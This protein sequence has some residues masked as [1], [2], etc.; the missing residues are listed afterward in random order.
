MRTPLNE[1]T[2]A[3]QSHVI[4][5]HHYKAFREKTTKLNVLGLR[6]P[7]IQKLEH[8]GFS[9]YQEPSKS[10]L[11]TWTHI[12]N[13]T[14]I[15]EV[16]YLPLFYYRRNRNLLDP[17][18]WKT[19]KG[20]VNRIENWEHADALCQ[21]YSFFYEQHP[22]LVEPTLRAWN[23]SKNPW[24]KRASI[25][26]TIYY[27]SRNRNAPS[28]KTVF[29]LIEPLITHKN[30]YVQKAVGWQLREAYKLE[31]KRALTFIQRHL[32]ELAPISY[33]YATEHVPAQTR[34]SM[35]ERRRLFRALQK[36]GT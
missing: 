35:K 1:V 6:L 9:F 20:W 7:V 16:M 23:K 3:L 33:S 30:P 26:S 4:S 19:M 12:W 11:E 28:L 5:D 27:A 36:K 34:A 15:H 32:V 13:T 21:L 2:K 10:I 22:T 24:H 29:E 17:T 31:P 8:T 25:V 18:H 14:D